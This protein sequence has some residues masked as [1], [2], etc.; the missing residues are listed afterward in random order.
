MSTEAANHALSDI[1][2]LPAD[3]L[4]FADALFEI[5]TKRLAGEP[6]EAGLDHPLT[7][8]PDGCYGGHYSGLVTSPLDGHGHTYRVTVEVVS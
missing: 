5:I 6:V 7:L 8:T 2:A 1:F 4:V 3:G